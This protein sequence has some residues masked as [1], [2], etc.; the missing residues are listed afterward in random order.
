MA[1]DLET[2]L[3]SGITAYYYRIISLD[4]IQ[5]NGGD[6][7]RGKCL[8]GL[9]LNEISRQAGKSPIVTRELDIE[10][11]TPTL[12]GSDNVFQAAYVV[13]KGMPEFENAE[14]I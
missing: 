10:I 5:F 9:Y 14:D 3:S 2:T 11:P 12:D 4:L 8:L 7:A 13:L 1:L 6:V